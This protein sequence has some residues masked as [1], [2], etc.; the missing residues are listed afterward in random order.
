MSE[1]LE[2]LAQQIIDQMKQMVELQM[3]HTEAIE[4]LKDMH[5]DLVARVRN[6]EDESL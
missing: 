4:I 6:L 2:I 5:A 1:P 3:N